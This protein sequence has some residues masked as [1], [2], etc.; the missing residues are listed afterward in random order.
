MKVKHNIFLWRGSVVWEQE[1]ST[2][3]QGVRVG[4]TILGWAAKIKGHWRV[5]M[6]TDCSK[7]FF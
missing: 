1:H 7:S 5:N 3:K 2:G 6:E 4:Y